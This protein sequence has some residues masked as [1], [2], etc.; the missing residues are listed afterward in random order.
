MNLSP[1]SGPKCELKNA[2]YKALLECSHANANRGNK[3]PTEADFYDFMDTLP[4][5]QL[6]E[7]LTPHLEQN[8]IYL[9][10]D[11]IRPSRAKKPTT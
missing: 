9:K 5:A 8:Q 10:P 11:R 3:T 7:A 1:F 6:A 2:L 4:P